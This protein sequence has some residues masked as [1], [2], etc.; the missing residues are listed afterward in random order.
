MDSASRHDKLIIVILNPPS[1]PG[2]LPGL[3]TTVRPFG[4]SSCWEL[5]KK[6][7]WL[8][9]QWRIIA[10]RMRLHSHPKIKNK[11]SHVKM[12]TRVNCEEH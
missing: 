1:E 8:F 2:L 7:N 4:K 9:K 3:K 11:K 6:V 12:L 10:S 5:D